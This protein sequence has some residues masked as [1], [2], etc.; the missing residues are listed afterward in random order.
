MCDEKQN[1]NFPKFKNG[2]FTSSFNIDDIKRLK[3]KIYEF[4][5][6]INNK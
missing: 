2:I 1:L 6:N 5:L 3:K 4:S